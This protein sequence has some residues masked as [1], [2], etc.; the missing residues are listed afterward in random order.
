MEILD[1]TEGE[2]ARNGD[3]GS[4]LH[5]LAAG[6]AEPPRKAARTAAEPPGAPAA[7]ARGAARALG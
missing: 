3:G 5:A 1:N 7:P 4:C 6:M 2:I